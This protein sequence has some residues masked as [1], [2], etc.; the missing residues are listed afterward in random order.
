MIENE[1]GKITARLFYHEDFVQSED[2]G[3]VLDLGKWEPSD[4]MKEG[5][6][7]EVTIRRY[8]FQP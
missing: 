4:G 2:K 3:W 5:D 7:V 8:E 6:W 1:E